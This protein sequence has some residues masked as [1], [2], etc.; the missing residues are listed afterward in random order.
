MKRNNYIKLT[1]TNKEKGFTLLEV[2][3]AVSV[4]A[5]G[6]LAVASMQ[7]TAIRGNHLSGSLTGA[8]TL[9]GDRVEKLMGMG[10][11]DADLDVGNHSESSDPYTIS[12][13]VV[14]NAAFDNTKT[15]NVTVGWTERGTQKSVVMQCVKAR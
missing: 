13:T 4:L 14:Q 5:F 6:L 8:S 11:S 3:V 12:W 7:G 15:V 1:K 10:Y 2:F 9:A